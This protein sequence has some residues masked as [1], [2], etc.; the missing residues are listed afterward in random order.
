LTRSCQSSSPSCARRSQR[1]RDLSTHGRFSGH[2]VSWQTNCV[3][4]CLTDTSFKKGIG[5]RV[6]EML[7]DANANGDV[8][9]IHDFCSAITNAANHKADFR[10]VSIWKYLLRLCLVSRADQMTMSRIQF[11]GEAL[12]TQNDSA[13]PTTGV[14]A[15]HFPP[16]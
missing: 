1:R 2:P 8:Y 5:P 12:A 9:R 15:I 4:D 3:R 6:L 7:L 11:P 10:R 14:P 13:T 16:S